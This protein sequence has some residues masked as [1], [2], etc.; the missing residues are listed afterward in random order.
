MISRF[1]PILVFLIFSFAAVPAHAGLMDFFFP[2]LKAE[3]PDPSETLQAPFATTP[4]K[5]IEDG[6]EEAAQDPPKN[7]VP[8]NMPHRA[9]SDVSKWVMT[10]ISEVLTLDGAQKI[11]D[12][13]AV[14]LYLDNAGLGQFSAFLTEQKLSAVLADG[15]YDMRSYVRDTPLLLNTGVVAGRYRWLYEVPV[16]LSF[17]KKGTSSYK[18]VQTHNKNYI[19]Q[20]QIGRSVDAKND[21][22]LFIER[23]S[24]KL[25]KQ[26]KK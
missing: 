3:G 25:E 12:N 1:L 2:S 10:S 5:D 15:Q 13:E 16:M 8:L 23:W 6:G 7:A 22:G 19:L 4:E 17:L 26:D 24:G 21:M 18:N 11:E 20:I 14:K 9:A